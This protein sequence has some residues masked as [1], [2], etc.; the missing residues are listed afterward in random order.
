MNLQQFSDK[1]ELLSPTIAIILI[2]LS[3]LVLLYI[4]DNGTSNKQFND[5]SLYPY[6]LELEDYN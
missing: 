2:C 5:P 1:H 6:I 3:S 4:F